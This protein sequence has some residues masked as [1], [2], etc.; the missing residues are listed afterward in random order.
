M[1]FINIFVK[2]KFLVQD[3]LKLAQSVQ[4]FRSNIGRELSM[5]PRYISYTDYNYIDN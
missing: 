5:I 2:F 3:I 4:S 1:L